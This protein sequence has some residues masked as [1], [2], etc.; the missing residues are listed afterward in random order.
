[1]ADIKATNW[2]CLD[3]RVR[4]EGIF[5]LGGDLGEI[6]LGLHVYEGII[7]RSLDY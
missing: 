3:G 1:M 5:T 2:S 6:L 4:Q 7:G